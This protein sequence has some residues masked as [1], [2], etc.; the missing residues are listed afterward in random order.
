[1]NSP[2]HRLYHEQE[3]QVIILVAALLF[4]LLGMAAL[5]LDLG[6]AMHAQRELQASTDAAATA[7]ALDLSNNLSSTTAYQSAYCTSG[8]DNNGFKSA[9]YASLK[10]PSGSSYG[11]NSAADLPGVT[12]VTDSTA[13]YPVA[14]CLSQLT[15]LG[16][17]CDNTAGANAIAVEEQVTVPTFFGKIFGIKSIPLKAQALAAMKGGTPTPANIMVIVDS[18]ASMA[19]TDNKCAS[20]TGISSPSRE[21]CSKYGVRTLL[22]S[23]APCTAGA[24]SCASTSVVDQVTL[25]TFPGLASSSDAPYDYN[26]CGNNFQSS[27]VAPYAGP[28]TSQPPYFTIVQNASD[29]KSTSTTLNGASSDIVKGVDWKDGNSCNNTQYGIQNPGGE[30]TY[31]A[32]VITEAQSDLSA[33]TG[34]RAKMQGAIILLSDG[35]ANSNWVSGGPSNGS[36][37]TS[38]TPSSYGKQECHQAITA[39]QTAAS[40]KNAVGLDT[41]VYAV[42][43]GATNSTSDCSTDTSPTITPCTTLGGGETTGGGGTQGIASDA[44]KFY[45]DDASGNCL[46]PAHPTITDLGTIFTNI[47]YDFLTTRLLPVSW[48]NGGTW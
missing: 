35:A 15:A 6:F 5:S 18:T 37:F 42:A 41:W 45:S 1:M 34:A 44:N 21:D 40:T 32:G 19:T 31:Y 30:G 24:T 43:Y 38:A 29:Y 23:L 17:A 28:P 47:S 7:G 27:Y 36:Q 4:G 3:G 13:T 2:F 48:Y 33:I 10:C 26:N 46:S 8:V 14:A 12:M 39:A 22:T 20:D 11:A 9:G 25:L 16:L